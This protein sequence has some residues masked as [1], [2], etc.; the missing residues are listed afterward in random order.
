MKKIVAVLTAHE[1][2]TEDLKAL[3]LGMRPK[4]REEPGNQRWDIWQDQTD[5]RKFVLDELYVDAAAV[6][7][8]RATPHFQNYVSK[9][10]HLADRMAL[11]VDPIEV[12]GRP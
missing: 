2:K 8:H 5:P 4:C 9:I 11:V 1:G 3:L 10:G 7:A 6:D 12:A